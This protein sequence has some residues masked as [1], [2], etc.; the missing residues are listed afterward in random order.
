MTDEQTSIAHSA[1]LNLVG[2]LHDLRS[3]GD[4]VDEGFS[5]MADL[6]EALLKAL[7][8]TVPPPPY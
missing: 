3:L 4:E 7:D 1:R 8:Q 5:L 2:A 6:I